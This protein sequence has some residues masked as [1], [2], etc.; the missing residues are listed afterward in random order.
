MEEKRT[1]STGII[2]L[3]LVLIIALAS[4]TTIL[5]YKE[6]N[7]KNINHESN[8][9]NQI[10]NTEKQQNE[11]NKDNIIATASKLVNINRKEYNVSVQ[12]E[13]TTSQN[14]YTIKINEK[15]LKISKE[16]ASPFKSFYIGTIED[17]VINGKQYAVVQI[18]TGSQ[19]YTDTWFF[20][21]NEKA[22]KV[23]EVFVSGFCGWVTEKNEDEN[24]ND[25]AHPL[26]HSNMINGSIVT[27]EYKRYGIDLCTYYMENEKLQKHISKTYKDGEYGIAGKSY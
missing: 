10:N 21:I 16:N 15:S 26:L 5:I 13:K 25:T 22:E 19:Y 1:I 3:I 18:S 27:Y 24:E 14:N 17:N 8:M 6:V 20:I 9:Q 12:F 23:G 2:I 7:N 11:E 4:V